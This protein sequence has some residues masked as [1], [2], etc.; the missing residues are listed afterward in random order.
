MTRP[1][2]TLVVPMW[3]EAARIEPTVTALNDAF[4]R[5]V[6]L[7]FV[8]DGSDDGSADVVE[9]ACKEAGVDA[10]VCRLPVNQG[11]GAAVRTGMLR[12][13]GEIVA[14]VDADLSAGPTDIEHVLQ[15]V[16]DGADVALASRALRGATITVPQP[17]ARR[18]SGWLFNVGLRAAGL[19]R[20]TDT[21]CGLKAFRADVVP[22]LFEPLRASGFG[23]DVEVLARAERLGLRVTE[24][25]V[26]WHHVEGS[27]LS[28]C[29]DGIATLKEVWSVRRVLQQEARPASVPTR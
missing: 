5:S 9:R 16:M 7:V 17:F 4:G 26:E 18:W 13:R 27:R 25:P 1:T 19:T 29:R 23:F 3:N 24:V 22:W 20:F 15:A 2:T 6:E 10:D 11:K 14:F 8:D 28:P 21:Q 12:A